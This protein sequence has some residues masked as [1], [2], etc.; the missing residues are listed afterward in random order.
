MYNV[1]VCVCVCVSCI[2]C[3]QL[4]VTLWTVAHQVLLSM[5]FSRQEYWSGALLQRIFST[6]ESNPCLSLLHWQHT[7]N[8]ILV[9]INTLHKCLKCNWIKNLRTTKQTE[10]RHIDIFIH[11][12]CINTHPVT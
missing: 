1:C 10:G 9:S 2:S 8:S 6:Q 7:F 11:Y 3:D 5:G 4:F 12:T